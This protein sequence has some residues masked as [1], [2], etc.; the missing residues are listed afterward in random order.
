MKNFRYIILL[1]IGVCC[2]I[3]FTA[4]GEK[5]TGGNIR[6][7]TSEETPEET[8]E[9]TLEETLGKVREDVQEKTRITEN[10]TEQNKEKFYEMTETLQLDRAERERFY[11]RLCE[12]NVFR[13]ETGKLTA[14]R[15]EDLDENGQ[16]DMIAMVQ[17]GEFF[18]YGEG[19]IYFYMNA[20]EAYCFRDDDYPFF[21]DLNVVTGDF[22][23]DGNI[24]IVFESHGTGCGAAGDW[25]PRILKY[26]GHTMEKMDFPS[27]TYEDD[28]REIYIEITQELQANTYSAYCPYLDETIGFEAENIFEPNRTRVVGGNVGGFFN[29]CSTEYE[30]RDAL[31]VSEYLSGEGGNVHCVGLA[32]LLILWEKDG[33]GRIEKWWIDL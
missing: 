25:Y 9:E 16:K 19:C 22:D 24:E 23:D 8:P 21:F 31:V 33:S 10:K 29:I 26:N 30:G 28:D 4:C 2:G 3:I 13:D 1:W 18:L 15:I 5:E 7:E 12:D 27:E 17:E 6:E 20:D 14:L 11:E 32:K